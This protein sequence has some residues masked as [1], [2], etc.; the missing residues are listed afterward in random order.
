MSLLTSPLQE[1]SFDVFR[2]HWFIIYILV[3]HLPVPHSASGNM[4]TAGSKTGLR[5][6]PC[7]HSRDLTPSRGLRCEAVLTGTPPPQP[8]LGRTQR[9]PLKT[10]VRERARS[11]LSPP[12][13]RL[14]QSHIR[15]PSRM[16]S[17]LSSPPRSLPTAP[18]QA[19]RPVLLELE[20]PQ[21]LCMRA[22][23]AEGPCLRPLA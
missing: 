5:P 18:F 12:S 21:G 7:E 23:L 20:K 13:F 9:E 11:A 2:T 6:C 4:I 15:S 14:T 16:R 1:I 3:G 17:S 8:L 19:T 22:P 10:Q